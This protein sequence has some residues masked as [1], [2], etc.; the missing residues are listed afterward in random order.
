MTTS[1]QA[2]IRAIY[3]IVVNTLAKHN[4]QDH[5]HTKVPSSEVLTLA[6]YACLENNGNYSKTLNQFSETC[7]F[8]QIL[9]KSRFGRR[10]AK[11]VDFLPLIINLIQ[12]Q[13]RFTIN[14]NILLTSEKNIFVIDTKPI[15]ICE[16]IRIPRC[17]LA[18][19]S[20]QKV[21]E[22][23]RGF[24]ASKKQYYY[25]FKLSLLVDCLG[26]PKEYSLHPASTGDLQA[27]YHLNLDLPPSSEILAD[28]IYNC[29]D[30]EQ[31]LFQTQ[32]INLTPIRKQN[33]KTGRDYFKQIRVRLLRRPIETALSLY[34]E[35]VPRLRATSMTGA[36]IKAHLSVVAFAFYQGFRVGVLSY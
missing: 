21:D 26:L 3:K 23:Y 27:F 33:M 2:K 8:K 16:N 15:A 4:H 34:C 28:K 14:N 30:V 36:V 10:L 12:Q 29:Q 7:I 25:G 19:N 18:G 13:S 32:Q 35:L 11:L 6:I 1:L 22:D 31:H 24:T 20:W 9:E 5:Y 17:K